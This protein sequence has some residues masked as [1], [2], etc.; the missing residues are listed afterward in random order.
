MVGFQSTDLEPPPDGV[1]EALQIELMVVVGAATA[2]LL[3]PI[4]IDL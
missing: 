4:E 3:A 1:D 2:I